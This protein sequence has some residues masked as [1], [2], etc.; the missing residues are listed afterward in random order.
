MAKDEKTITFQLGQGDDPQL[1]KRV[2]TAKLS[3]R[4]INPSIQIELGKGRNGPFTETNFMFLSAGQTFPAGAIF[5]RGFV[6]PGDPSQVD[7]TFD[8]RT[9]GDAETS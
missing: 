1:V 2:A 4:A 9:R 8:V 6:G 5:A 7:V 3:V